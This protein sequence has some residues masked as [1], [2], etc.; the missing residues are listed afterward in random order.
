M[1]LKWAFATRIER[2][3]GP[4]QLQGKISAA[5]PTFGA[6]VRS[7]SWLSAARDVTVVTVANLNHLQAQPIIA[8]LKVMS[9][10]NANG[11]SRQLG[12][13]RTRERKGT[14]NGHTISRRLMGHHIRSHSRL[15]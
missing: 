5:R 14:S 11:P 3:P 6:A 12:E 15:S 13:I 7:W 8:S 10:D 2:I 9:M 4:A 1:F